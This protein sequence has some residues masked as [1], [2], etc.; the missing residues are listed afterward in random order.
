MFI[1]TFQ[2]RTDDPDALRGRLD[3]WQR[4]H[5]DKAQGWLG[6]TAGV[7]DDGE[8]VAIVRFEDE[9]AARRNS[10]RPEQGH[11]W[12]DTEPHFSEAPEFADYPDADVL[13]G[14][15]SDEAG[16]VQVIK[17]RTTDR[18]RLRQLTDEDELGEYRPEILGGSYGADNQDNVIEVVYFSSEA[19]AREGERKMP[20]AP[21]DVRANYDEYQ[22]LLTDV[23]YL[24]LRTPWFWSPR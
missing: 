12:S 3:A 2:G 7:T 23:R 9:E 5:A 13:M 19:E 14:G 20:D 1:Q 22:Q 16:F 10:D 11:W 17:G 15:G 18:D 8:F 24:D 21:D 6:T 4:D